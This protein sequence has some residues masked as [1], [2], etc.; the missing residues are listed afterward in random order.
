MAQKAI[1]GPFFF[2]GLPCAGEEAGYLPNLTV[3]L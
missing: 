3:L 2:S 1:S